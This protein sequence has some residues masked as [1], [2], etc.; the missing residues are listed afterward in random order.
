MPS[1]KRRSKSG[2]ATKKNPTKPA[3][4]P[5]PASKTRASNCP[6]AHHQPGDPSKLSCSCAECREERGE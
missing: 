6:N 4:K 3:A 2:K 1:L 5:K